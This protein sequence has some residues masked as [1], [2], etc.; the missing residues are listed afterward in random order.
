MA[1]D[2]RVVLERLLKL[3]IFSGISQG[4]LA[5]LV[6][7]VEVKE[8]SEGDKL[9]EIG[10]EGTDVALVIEGSFTV[11]LGEGSSVLPLAWVSAGEV[12]GETALFRR[13][14]TRTA[15]V[16]A[17]QAATVM[18]FDAGILEELSNRGNGVPR[19]LEEAVM[20][21]LARRIHDSVEA[22]DGVLGAHIDQPEKPGTLSRLRELLR[23]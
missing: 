17:A 16:R 13:S 9:M 3:P 10:D 20:R 5:E 8:L 18:R 1:K 21:T 7:L 2:P 22:I 14:A 4:D 15:R 6:E 11:E 19:A 12:L 23:R